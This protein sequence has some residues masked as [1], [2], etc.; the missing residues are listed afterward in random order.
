LHS[1]QDIEAG[2]EI[3]VTEIDISPCLKT[4]VDKGERRPSANIR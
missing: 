4:L 3:E 1:D 2:I